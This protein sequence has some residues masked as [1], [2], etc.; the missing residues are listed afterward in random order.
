MHK[1]DLGP[2]ERIVEEL[3]QQ[4]DLKPHPEGGFYRELYRS[5]LTV[6][7]D[8]GRSM[9]PALTTI[10]FLLPAGQVSRWH[11]V[12]SD[13]VW[14]HLDGAPLELFTCDPAFDRVTQHVIGPLR[15][16]LRPEL[17]VEP[18]HWQAARSIGTYSIAACVVG[19]GFDFADFAMLHDLPDERA[20]MERQQAA[21][22]LLT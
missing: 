12:A 3:I 20:K 18:Q 14:L 21:F 15:D 19:P 4:L 13:E 6:H 16:G 7:P 8:D 11:R 1:H 5:P 2:M 22:A 10:Y 17:V 9:R